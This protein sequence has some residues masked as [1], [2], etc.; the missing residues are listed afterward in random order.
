MDSNIIIEN[1]NL[2]DYIMFKLDKIDNGFTMEELDQITEVVIDFKEEESSAA[3]FEELL[4]LRKLNSI[5]LRNV[6]IFNDDFKTLLALPE[7]NDVTFENCEFEDADLISSL[8]LKSLS[9]VNDKIN[10]YTFVNLFKS[11][12]ELTIVNGNIEISKINEL[13][14]LKYLQISYSNINDDSSINITSLEE[15]YIDNTN[16]NSFE[17]LNSLSNLKRL[18]IDEKQYNSNKELFSNLENKGILV[19]NENMTSFGGEEDAL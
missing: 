5:I 10:S 6:F 18:S 4:K 17:F 3:V 14:D 15:L 8:N 11:L 19:L 2:A 9:L 12:E 7:L 1:E 16:I 13:Q